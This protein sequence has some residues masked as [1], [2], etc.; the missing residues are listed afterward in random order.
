MPTSQSILIT[1]AGSG[2]GR[3]VCALPGARRLSHHRHRSIAEAA[4]S[5]IDEILKLGGQGSA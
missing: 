1:G 4:Q 5:T 3:G 2:I